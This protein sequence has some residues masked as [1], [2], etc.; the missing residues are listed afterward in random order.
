MSAGVP[1]DPSVGVL[2]YF[3]S[4][5]VTRWPSRASARGSAPQTSASPPVLANGRASGVTIRMSR[6]LGAALR[7][8]AAF[9]GFGAA[10]FGGAGFG[11]A[12]FG[13]AGF[14]GAATF[15]G[16]AGAGTGGGTGFF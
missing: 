14:F 3:G 13:A 6:P 7:G 16:S 1:G 12:G 5:S 9:A 4:T 2:R 8:A 11:A 15:G 10:G